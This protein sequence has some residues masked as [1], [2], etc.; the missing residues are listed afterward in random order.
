MTGENLLRLLE[1]RLDNVVFRMGF[2]TSARPGA[3]A[4]EPRPLRRQRPADRHP[5][6]PGQ[7]GRPDR[8]PRDAAAAGVLQEASRR[9]SAARQRPDWLSVDAAKLAGTVVT[10]APPRPDAARA[11][12]AARGRVLLEVTAPHDRTR[13]PAD[14]ARRGARDVR[15][16]RGEPARGRLRRHP[17]QRAAARAA[18][19]ARGRRGD[20]AS[21]SA[22]STTSSRPSRASRKTS[23]RSS[24]TS[25]SS[26]SRATP[27]IRSSSSWSRAA[28]ARS[29]RPTSSSRP[30]SRSSTPS[31]C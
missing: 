25:R 27:P 6:V 19:L 7:A 11:Q 23:P 26:G 20:V 10:P 24:S 12:R 15:Q 14:R 22:T 4:R 17:R 1:T 9:R 21:R 30:T 2:A 5:V 18:V 29:P 16:V 8:G 3:P 13:E 28:P 31:R